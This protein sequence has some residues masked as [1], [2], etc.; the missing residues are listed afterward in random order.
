MSSSASEMYL[1]A[2]FQEETLAVTMERDGGVLLD[3]R[4]VGGLGSGTGEGVSPEA[5]GASR[6]ECL[7]KALLRR[8][9]AGIDGVPTCRLGGGWPL[10]HR[11]DRR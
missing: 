6:P 2:V 10:R 9:G 8:P 1:V 4:G 5:G 7:L 11:G 3:L